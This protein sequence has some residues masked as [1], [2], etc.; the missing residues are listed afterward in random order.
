MIDWQTRVTVSEDK[1][2]NSDEEDTANIQV[3][4]A[5][6]TTQDDVLLFTHTRAPPPDDRHKLACRYNLHHHQLRHLYMTVTLLLFHH[7]LITPLSSSMTTYQV[8]IFSFKT[9]MNM[10]VRE[11][12]GEIFQSRYNYYWSSFLSM[13]VRELRGDIFQSR[14][15]YW[16]SFLSMAVRELRGDI[17]QQSGQD[18][19]D[20]HGQCQCLSFS[21]FLKNSGSIFFSFCKKSQFLSP[22]SFSFGLRN[23][24]GHGH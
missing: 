23:S 22:K 9:D 12:R 18:L 7:H 6:D 14:Y 2:K 16:S 21:F 10:A 15:N 19:V 8:E 11:L 17:F 4:V 5:R 20:I 3:L 24:H 13:A 1:S